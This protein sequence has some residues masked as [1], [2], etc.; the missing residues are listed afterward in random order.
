MIIKKTIYKIIS[1]LLSKFN[2]KLIKQDESYIDLRSGVNNYRL[3]TQ[4][5]KPIAVKLPIANARW[6]ALPFAFNEKH[7]YIYSLNMATNYNKSNLNIEI[8]RKELSKYYKLVQPKNMEECLGLEKSFSLP[9]PQ[10]THTTRWPWIKKEFKKKELSPVYVNNKIKLMPIE[11]HGVQHWG[12]VSND[13]LETEVLKLSKLYNS[14]KNNGYRDD[15][16]DSDGVV[17]GYILEKENLEWVWIPIQGQHRVSVASALQ[18]KN[19]TVKVMAIYREIDIDLF[20]LVVSNIYSKDESKKIFNL[21][22][23]KTYIKLLQ[24]W[25]EYTN[26]DKNV[27]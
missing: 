19:I 25:I 15:L 6:K 9:K 23:T 22:F 11:K 2:L 17:R 14:I 5:E 8:L 20:P 10:E 27:K 21:F 7:P 24:S 3:F 18:L 13:K 12:P 4:Y 26:K 1:K 16:S